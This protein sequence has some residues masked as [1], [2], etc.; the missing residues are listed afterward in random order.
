MVL[1]WVLILLLAA[2]LLGVF[3]GPAKHRGSAAFLKYSEITRAGDTSVDLMVQPLKAVRLYY[4]VIP[5]NS[6]DNQTTDQ[7]VGI[8]SIRVQQSVVTAARKLGS[9]KKVS[10]S[11]GTMKE[12][13]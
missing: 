5:T 13:F 8:D 7:T 12:T 9:D 6:V 11:S 4:V 2:I 3:L 10:Y 1:L